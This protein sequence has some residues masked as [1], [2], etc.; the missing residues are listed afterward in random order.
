VSFCGRF[1]SKRAPFRSRRAITLCCVLAAVALSACS[2]VPKVPQSDPAQQAQASSSQSLAGRLIVKVA[3]NGPQQPARSLN[4]HF[5]LRG[6][7]QRGALDLSTPLGSLLAQARWEPEAAWLRTPRGETRFDNLDTL[8]QKLLGQTVP[9]AA[10]FDWLRARPWAGAPH[11]ALD[12]AES[13]FTQIG[14][15]VDVSRWAKQSVVTAIRLQAPTV[16][17]SAQLERP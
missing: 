15:R 5:E 3:E 11:Q 16:T 10:L 12:V 1:V 9:V 2:N 14:W 8:S 13:G 17:V 4:A 6:Q 7:A